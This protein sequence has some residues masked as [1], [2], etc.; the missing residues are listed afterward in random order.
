MSFIL[1]NVITPKTRVVDQGSLS[2]ICWYLLRVYKTKKIQQTCFQ[3][4]KTFYLKTC[5][6]KRH[7]FPL[8]FFYSQAKYTWPCNL[9]CHKSTNFKKDKLTYLSTN[10]IPTAGELKRRHLKED[11]SINH[12]MHSFFLY[13]FLD[14][15]FHHVW[16]SHGPRT[17]WTKGHVKCWIEYRAKKSTTHKLWQIMKHL[18]WRDDNRITKLWPRNPIKLVSNGFKAFQRD[19]KFSTITV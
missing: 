7:A 17:S 3:R 19:F 5:P 15:I 16:K 18:N 6:A 9:R 14:E 12:W 4:K 10:L 11:L 1:W 13:F 8:R 2:E